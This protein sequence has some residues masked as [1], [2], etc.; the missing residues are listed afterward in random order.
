MGIC[1]YSWEMEK[2]FGEKYTLGNENDTA[3]RR[4][5]ATKSFR[6]QKYV[7]VFLHELA[8]FTQSEV[9]NNVTVYLA[10]A[11]LVPRKCVV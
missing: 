3:E 6:L 9:K 7:V 4:G 11:S 8:R 10:S 2:S 1:F 5:R